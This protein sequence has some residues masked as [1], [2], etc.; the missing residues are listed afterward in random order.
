MP[1]QPQPTPQ[2][3]PQVVPQPQLFSQ[4]TFLQRHGRQQ[5]SLFTNS[6]SG[7]RQQVF[8]QQAFSEQAF[9]QQ[10]G[11]AQHIGFAQ[12]TF[13]QQAGL[14]HS[15]RQVFT[16]R[17]FSQQ[18]GWQ[19]A[20]LAQQA[21][22]AQH[23]GAQHFVQHLRHSNRSFRPPNRS[24]TGVGRQQQVFSQQA[25]PQQAGSGAQHFAA[26]WQQATFSQA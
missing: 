12:A 9:S 11:F 8:S 10:A 26:C 24:R 25:L 19:H 6:A 15:G 1:P 4:Q 3:V 13:S 17:G 7:L 20:G 5:K 14:Q 22:A 18:A 23:A 21:G 2:V 16:Q